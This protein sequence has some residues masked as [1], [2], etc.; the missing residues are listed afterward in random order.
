MSLCCHSQRAPKYSRMAPPFH[1][2]ARHVLL[3]LF[4]LRSQPFAGAKCLWVVQDNVKLHGEPA[5]QHRVLHSVLH[6]R[7]ERD[8]RVHLSALLDRQPGALC[9]IQHDVRVMLR[10]DNAKVLLFSCRYRARQYLVDLDV[11][12]FGPL[13]GSLTDR[14]DRASCQAMFPDLCYVSMWVNNIRA[15]FSCQQADNTQFKRQPFTP[16]CRSFCSQTLEGAC[17][18]FRDAVVGRGETVAMYCELLP[19]LNC[20][21]AAPAVAAPALLLTLLLTA[22]SRLAL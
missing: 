13:A 18:T 19:T 15:G 20:F 5:E 10:F 17:P 4:I 6:E 8:A 14:A 3:I 9:A 16:P 1:R 22:L 7:A 12:G 11:N 21:S 2:R